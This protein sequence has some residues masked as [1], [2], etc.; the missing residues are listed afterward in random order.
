M[1]SNHYTASKIINISNIYLLTGNGVL[2][3]REKTLIVHTTIYLH[4]FQDFNYMY[5]LN[6]ISKSRGGLNTKQEYVNVY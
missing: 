5:A 2:P 4:L 1:L 6:C 3:P